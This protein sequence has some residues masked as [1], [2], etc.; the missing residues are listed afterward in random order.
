M[1]QAGWK[2]GAE[3][4]MVLRPEEQVPRHQGTAQSVLPHPA[5]C[6]RL[7]FWPQMPLLSLSSPITSSETKMVISVCNFIARVLE[8]MFPNR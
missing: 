6:S 7:P 3:K 8:V 4:A 1:S 2:K 5:A